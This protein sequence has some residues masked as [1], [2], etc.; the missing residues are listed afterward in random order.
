M[1]ESAKIPDLDMVED[2]TSAIIARTVGA[3]LL[4]EQCAT[5]EHGAADG[6][7]AILDDIEAKAVKLGEHGRRCRPASVEGVQR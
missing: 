2:L 4:V 1:N 6:L 3:A 7:H 5:G